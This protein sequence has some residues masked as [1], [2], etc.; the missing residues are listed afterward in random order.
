MKNTNLTTAMKP[1]FILFVCLASFTVYGQN[2]KPAHHVLIGYS[3]SPDYS[4]RTLNNTGGSSSTDLVIKRRNEVELPK[5]G[6]TTGLNILVNFSKRAGLETG[7]QFSARGYKGKGMNL[8][9]ETPDPTLVTNASS[10]YSYQYIGIPLTARFG[11]GKSKVRFVSSVG[12]ITGFL[13]N[14]K[15]ITTYTYTNGRRDKQAQSIKD[16]ARIDISPLI[17]IGVDYEV[18]DKI[19]LIAEPTFRYGV[20]KTKDAPVGEHLWSAGLNMGIYY[21]LK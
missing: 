1:L 17:S 4:F 5:F 8:V 6:F 20:T 18:T 10:S 7:L 12:F 2:S 14:A 15:Q 11:F 19:H 13:L 9:F 16:F 21:G 3:F